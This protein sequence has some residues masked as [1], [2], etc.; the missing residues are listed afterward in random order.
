MLLG[1]E[2]SLALFQALILLWAISDLQHAL[3]IVLFC[4]DLQIS[5]LIDSHASAV[6]NG[7]FHPILSHVQP[8]QAQLN[9]RDLS[10][11]NIR[12]RFFMKS[13]V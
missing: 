13:L 3:Q 10:W 4:C 1:P 7:R 9:G 5:E 12:M 6:V 11:V 8:A 2:A